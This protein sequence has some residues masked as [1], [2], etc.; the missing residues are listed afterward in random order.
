MFAILGIAGPTLAGLYKVFEKAG[1]PG[2]AALVPVYN[3]M[4]LARIAGK[5][6]TYGLLMLIPIAGLY[7]SY[8][9]Y[10]EIAKSFGKDAG[11]TVGLLLLTPIFMPLLGFGNAPFRRPDTLGHNPYQR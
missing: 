8:F 2:W 5:E 9:V 4:I 11:Y 7:F 1:Q 3:V 10:D 6:E